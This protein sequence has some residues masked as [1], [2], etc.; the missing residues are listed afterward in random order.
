[1][2]LS[3]MLSSASKQSSTVFSLVFVL[4]WG[5]ASVVTVNCQL[6]GGKVSFFQSLCLL[7]Y[8]VFPLVISS[9]LGLFS[10]NVIYRAVVVLGGLFWATRASVV[11]LSQ[12]VKDDRRALAAYPTFLFYSVLAWLVFTE[13]TIV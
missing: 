7:G 1:M 13:G 3:L 12:L 5:G 2:A 11:F 10:K 6:L 9:F 4:V 8:C